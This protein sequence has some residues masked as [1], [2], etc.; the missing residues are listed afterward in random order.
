MNKLK[1][2][3]SKLS[4]LN[5]EEKDKI[6]CQWSKGVKKEWE[7]NNIIK[8]IEKQVHDRSNNIAVVSGGKTL[9]YQELNTRANE[10]AH[11]LREIGV[12]AEKM[13]AISLERGIEQIVWIIGI[14]K[15]GGCYIPIDPSYP[16]DRQKYIL[17]DS[18][19]E[20]LITSSKLS[21]QYSN[22]YHKKLIE[23]E[24][25][26]EELSNYSSENPPLITNEDNLAYVIY[27]SGSTGKPK[28]IYNRR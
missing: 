24:L 10:I 21:S 25:V 20:I 7:E 26:E 16:E 8:L 22:Y 19:T 5:S 14:L 13:I 1:I 11:Y 2:R 15:S 28:K 6:L 12:I 17:E 27:T 23:I 4:I 18:G 3:L 9:T